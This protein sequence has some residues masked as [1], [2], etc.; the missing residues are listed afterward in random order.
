MAALHESF[1]PT[2]VLMTKIAEY[3]HSKFLELELL[4]F[5]QLDRHRWKVSVSKSD[6]GVLNVIREPVKP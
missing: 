4:V 5:E 1:S 2:L 6:T 3:F